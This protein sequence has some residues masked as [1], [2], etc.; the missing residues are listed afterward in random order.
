[1][2]T[3]SGFLAG[4][5]QVNAAGVALDV[6]ASLAPVVD[7]A[8]IVRVA[9]RNGDDL[10]TAAFEAHRDELFTFLA[11]TMR[12]DPEAE[13]LVQETFL[14][15]AREVHA[16]RV[17]DQLRAWL[18]RVASNLAMSRFRRQ[19][20]VGRFL[21]KFGSSEAGGEMTSPETSALRRERSAAMEKALQTLQPEARLALVLAGQGFSGRDVARAI[22]R[23]EAATRTL[24]C[25]AR[26]R[27]RGELAGMDA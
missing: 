12:N 14:R 23:S 20:V 10:V 2:R 8:P 18:Y 19:S 7:V 27:L 24:M 26:L 13:D 21:T 22:G 3:D 15:L 25:R 11:R 1:M 16:G 9:A 6:D 17:P 5:Q 4:E